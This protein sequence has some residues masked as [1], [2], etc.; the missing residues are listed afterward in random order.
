MLAKFNLDLSDIFNCLLN[1]GIFLLNPDLTQ[2]NV[3]KTLGLKR[4]LIRSLN[5]LGIDQWRVQFLNQVGILTQLWK[6]KIK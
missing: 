5:V 3:F 6:G 1:L 4:F 2:T